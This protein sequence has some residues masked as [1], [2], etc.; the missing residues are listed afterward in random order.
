MRVAWVCLLLW[1][2]IFLN[3]ESAAKT[4]DLIIFSYNRPLQLYAYLE[5]LQHYTKNIQKTYIL[6]RASS[7]EFERGY[8]EVQKDF[9]LVEFHAQTRHSSGDFK[10]LLLKLCFERSLSEYI[11]FGVDDIIVTQ[12]FDVQKCVDA[13]EQTG[14]YGFYLRLGKNI[15]RSYFVPNTTFTLPEFNQL[16]PTILQWDLDRKNNISDW[17]YVN[18]VDMTI[19]KKEV[20][21]ETLLE[22]NYTAPNNLE[23]EWERLKK[24]PCGKGLCFDLS[25]C[26]NIPLNSVQTLWTNWN[27]NY[28]TVGDLLIIFN[29]GLKVDIAPFYRANNKAPHEDH[30]PTFITRNPK[31]IGYSFKKNITYNLSKSPL[32]ALLVTHEKDS[33]TLELAI[34]GIKK[35]V[36]NL[37]K[38]IVIS[39]K[40]LSDNAEWFN[41]ALFP[42]NKRA[43]A[44]EIFSG[45]SDQAEIYLKDDKTRIGWI[46]QQ[47]LKLYAQFIIPDISPNMLIVDS[48]TIFLQDIDFISES[49][50]GLYCVGTEYYKPYFEHA[51]RLLPGFEKIYPPH[52]GIVHHML[53]QRPILEDFFS[54]VEGIHNMPLWQALCTSIDKKHLYGSALSEYELYFNFAC[55]RT[56]QVSIRPLVWKN[57]SLGEC[58][59]NQLAK[60]GYDFVSC[61]DYL[62]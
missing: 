39:E 31:V 59:F 53:I 47:L 26:I 46:Y 37:R 8:Q 4:V 3:Q 44:L 17:Y 13:L 9:P 56:K 43:L 20:I 7:D 23:G 19:Y 34:A 35:H 55:A 11:V 18:T 12:F 22:L 48:D 40:K 54:T 15:N 29:K 2:S 60:D 49:G 28:A 27:M 5:S 14:S 52:S 33:K 6:Y 25:A 16:E 1:G 38:I 51:A 30:V 32:D 24:G 58:D 42:F 10:P 41:E 21:K 36:K 50:G 61:H 57:N 45:N 62:G